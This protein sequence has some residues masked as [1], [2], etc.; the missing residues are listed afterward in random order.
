MELFCI[1]MNGIILY[2]IFTFSLLRIKKVDVSNI[3]SV[4]HFFK[5]TCE[6]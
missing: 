6:R 3:A 5:S 2:F 4:I 1:T